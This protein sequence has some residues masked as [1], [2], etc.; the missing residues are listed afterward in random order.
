M[1]Y[2]LAC[3][4]VIGLRLAIEFDIGANVSIQYNFGDTLLFTASPKGNLEV[5]KTLLEAG[6]F[7]NVAFL[8]KTDFDPM[9]NTTSNLIREHI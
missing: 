6:E 8:L 1:G 3:S 9:K 4:M 7:I 5:V 2:T